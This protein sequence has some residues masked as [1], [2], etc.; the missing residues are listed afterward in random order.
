MDEV[1]R[2]FM[3]HKEASVIVALK[4]AL[5]ITKEDI[6]IQSLINLISLLESRNGP[7]VASL[8][9]GKTTTY[10]SDKSAVEFIAALAT[11]VRDKVDSVILKSPYICILCDESTDI[12]ISKKLVVYC[13]VISPDVWTLHSICDKYQ[14]TNRYQ[15]RP[16][17]WDVES[18]K[19]SN[20]KNHEALMRQRLW[21]AQAL[22]WLGSCSVI[23]L[24]HLIITALPTG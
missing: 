8:K 14:S 12:S 5:W 15:K 4:A 17:L 23:I 3:H 18:E 13:R 6:A 22:G 7:N 2:K 21:Q 19:Y 11:V 24:C 10:Q 9:T 20:I 16:I 1:V